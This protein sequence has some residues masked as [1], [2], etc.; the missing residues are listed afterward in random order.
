MKRPDPNLV[1]RNRAI[2]IALLSAAIGVALGA[3]MPNPPVLCG[4][5]I[6]VSLFFHAKESDNGRQR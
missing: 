1:C 3:I 4:M 6:L 2:S 5:F